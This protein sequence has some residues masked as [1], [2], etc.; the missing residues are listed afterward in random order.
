MPDTPYG[1]VRMLLSSTGE[2]VNPDTFKFTYLYDNEILNYYADERIKSDLELNKEYLK[3]LKKGKRLST[4][5]HRS[6]INASLSYQS[7]DLFS[8]LTLLNRVNYP[9]I[10]TVT[11]YGD[12]I[13][14]ENKILYTQLEKNH[15]IIYTHLIQ[16]LEERIKALESGTVQ[17]KETLQDYLDDAGIPIQTC[18]D[19]PF[20]PGFVIH[21]DD[22]EPLLVEMRNPLKKIVS[23]SAGD[24]KE[25]KCDVIYHSGMREEMDGK[26]GKLTIK[27]GRLTLTAAGIRHPVFS[28]DLP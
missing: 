18:K 26:S 8:A 3:L 13:V 25:F 9:K 12:Q 21:N 22:G 14:K 28:Q 2:P 11:S 20:F 5:F 24:K 16:L 1:D 17:T 23:Y 7:F 4:S 19:I 27:D 6:A 10:K 15:K